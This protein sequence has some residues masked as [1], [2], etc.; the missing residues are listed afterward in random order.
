[1]RS[2]S[3]VVLVVA[4]LV[5][6]GC[7]PSVPAA[8]EVSGCPPAEWTPPES[9]WSGPITQV[10]P[11]PSTVSE[12]ANSMVVFGRQMAFPTRPAPDTVFAGLWFRRG[13]SRPVTV[14]RPPGAKFFIN[15]VAVM[16][17]RGTPHVL[18]AEPGLTLAD[19]GAN[20]GVLSRSVWAASLGADGW[21]PPTR[22]TSAG[23][24][25]WIES[26]LSPVVATPDGTLHFVVPADRVDVTG[27][28]LHLRL[29]PNGWSAVD[30]RLP[31]PAAHSVLARRDDELLLAYVSPVPSVSGDLNSLWFTR[32]TDYGVTWKPP[33]LV[34]RSGRTGASEPMI[35]A[36][37]GSVHLIWGQNLSGGLGAEVLR[38][39]E[40]KDS[41]ASWGPS[42]DL[43]AAGFLMT[44]GTVAD[45]RGNVHV[46]FSAF[47]DSGLVL[48]R[49][50]WCGASWSAPDRVVISGSSLGS[51]A[52][53]RTPSG[54]VG[55]IASALKPS[56]TGGTATWF[57]ATSR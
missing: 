33:V 28:L 53:Y 56:S 6:V 43:P 41:G 34:S 1:M 7:R 52:A 19:S 35:A 49:A 50:R 5:A 32:S 9:L 29:T 16:D 48:Q 22:V 47:G 42:T 26:G 44:Q 55:V 2:L 11:H 30:I 3:T 40:S 27:L 46:L 12:A 51:A 18:W 57:R 31:M 25:T 54:S 14:R 45:S 36:A 13:E 4:A 21:T 39:A 15:P 17:S 38:H 23:A 8:G 37:G 24:I 20:T 10:T